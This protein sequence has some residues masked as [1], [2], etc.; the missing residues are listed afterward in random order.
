MAA[1]TQNANYFNKLYISR[2][3]MRI[4][5]SEHVSQT[6][7]NIGLGL[8]NYEPNNLVEYFFFIIINVTVTN[9]I[10]LTE[11]KTI[12]KEKILIHVP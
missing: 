7:R 9:K 6:C 4:L 1:F 10:K 5:Y 8:N 3:K 2:N 12:G 11:V